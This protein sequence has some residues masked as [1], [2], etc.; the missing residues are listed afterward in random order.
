MHTL[1]RVPPEDAWG[2]GWGWVGSLMV[3]VGVGDGLE[4][5]ERW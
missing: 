2:W 3:R 1:R 4:L 5:A